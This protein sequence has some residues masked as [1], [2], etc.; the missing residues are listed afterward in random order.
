M[1]TVLDIFP[2]TELADYYK[3][4]QRALEVY[5]EN[6]ESFELSKDAINYHR[7]IKSLR[8]LKSHVLATTINRLSAE[9]AFE[10]HAPSIP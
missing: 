6:V 8:L 9:G 10:Q 3:K 2:S 1:K 5:N 4:L 7:K